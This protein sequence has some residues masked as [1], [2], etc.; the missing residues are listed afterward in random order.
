MNTLI[1]QVS[2]A[3]HYKYHMFFNISSFGKISICTIHNFACMLYAM[4]NYSSRSPLKLLMKETTRK[5]AQVPH[6]KVTPTIV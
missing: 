3:Y 5:E 1:L 6:T 4:D 2:Q